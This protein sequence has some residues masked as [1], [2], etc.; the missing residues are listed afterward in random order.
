[1]ATPGIPRF[2]LNTLKLLTILVLMTLLYIG[3][4]TSYSW[5]CARDEYTCYRFVSWYKK[6]PVPIET[7]GNIYIGNVSS[8]TSSIS[9]VTNISYVDR[10]I[11]IHYFNPNQWTGPDTFSKCSHKCSITFGRHYKEYSTS[12]YVIFDG[13]NTLPRHPPHKPTG[14]TWIYHGMEPPFLQPRLQNWR[15]KFN[16]TISYRRDA[17]FTHTYG[18]ML[19]NEVKGTERI[20]LKSKWEEKTQGTAWFVSHLNVP[21]RR[22]QYAKKLQNYVNV[23]IYSRRGSRKCPTDKIKDCEKLLSDRYKFYLSF[24][25]SLCRDYVT[26]KCFNIYRAQADVIPV[27]RGVED[28]SLFVPPNSYIDTAK[29]SNISSLA[30]MQMELANNRT[31]FENYFQWRRFYSNE[32]TRKR[33]FCQLCAEVH[34]VPVKQRLYD[35]VHTWVHG[36]QNNPMCRQASDIK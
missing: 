19:F 16:W 12:Q 36:D 33:A 7:K 6:L 32:P 17:E 3:V 24:E 2:S 20:K 8:K 31:A 15:R 34:R 29:V 5:L 11:R 9:S 28:Y 13:S 14:Q 30:Q 25:N 23:D 21:S 22:D 10:D 18:T 4:M 26:E 35:D 27:V 1:M